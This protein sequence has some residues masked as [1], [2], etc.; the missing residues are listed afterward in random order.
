LVALIRIR[1]VLRKTSIEP[2]LELVMLTISCRFAGSRSS[3]AGMAVSTS[4]GFGLVL[5]QVS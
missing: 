1:L 2:P 4:A 5:I 3:R